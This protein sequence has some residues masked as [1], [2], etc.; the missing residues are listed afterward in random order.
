ML[1]DHLGSNL[2]LWSGTSPLDCPS[3]TVAVAGC[4]LPSGSALDLKPQYMG[5]K[6]RVTSS[7]YHHPLCLQAHPDLSYSE[8]EIYP[9]QKSVKEGEVTLPWWHFSEPSSLPACERDPWFCPQTD[10]GLN[11][12]SCTSP[13]GQVTSSPLSF[14]FLFICEMRWY[15]LSL[16]DGVQIW[17]ANPARGLYLNTA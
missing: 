15:I 10:L 13:E 9:S 5:N 2:P 16:K 17:W 4:S 11:S 6:K 12:G 7:S 1:R 14:C 3:W 8:R